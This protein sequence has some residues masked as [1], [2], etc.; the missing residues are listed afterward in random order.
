[1]TAAPE[2][3]KLLGLEELRALPD[4]ESLAIAIQ[5]LLDAGEEKHLALVEALKDEQEDGL[6]DVAGEGI[7]ETMKR[8]GR[9]PTLAARVAAEL[10][11]ARRESVQRSTPA[12]VASSS[13]GSSY[14][15]AL[16][17][18]PLNW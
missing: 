1:M 11:R 14:V 5:A 13:T 4:R 16:G 9:V 2:Q 8:P 10:L 7:Y 15:P 17:N 18:D 3:V 12:L 6:V